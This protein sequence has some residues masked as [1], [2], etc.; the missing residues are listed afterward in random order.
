MATATSRPSPVSQSASLSQSVSQSLAV[1]HRGRPRRAVGVMPPVGDP[2]TTNWRLGWPLSREGSSPSA[3]YGRRRQKAAV[4]GSRSMFSGGNCRRGGR[5][6]TGTSS[7]GSSE[8]PGAPSASG[9]CS[10]VCSD[11]WPVTAGNRSSTSNQCWESR[12]V[13]APAGTAEQTAPAH[14]GT[15]R[16]GPVR[17]RALWAATDYRGEGESLRSAGGIDH[18]ASTNCVN[19][20]HGVDTDGDLAQARSEDR[21][22]RQL[23]GHRTTGAE[24][25]RGIT[26]RETKPAKTTGDD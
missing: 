7:S 4:L 23:A 5:V 16:L 25:V 9:R 15:S 22:D 13:A 14:T 17:R 12:S 3:D 24:N 10:P 11:T 8:L 1:G 20:S 21:G 2:G 26:Q 6:D 18:R 19:C